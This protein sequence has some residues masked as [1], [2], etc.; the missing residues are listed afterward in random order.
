MDS[1]IRSL[2][3]HLDGGVHAAP[4]LEHACALAAAL[5]ARI[6]ALFAVSP[7]FAALPGFGAPGV[8]LLNEVDP[9]SRRH[10]RACFDRVCRDAGR[11][12]RWGEVV[13]E[14]AAA[15]FARHGLH[16]DLMVLGQHD[17]QDAAARNVPADFIESV[18]LASGTPALVLPRSDSTFRGYGCIV[19]AWKP[20]PEAAHALKAAL[21]LLQRAQEVH[22]VSRCDDEDERARDCDA[23]AEYLRLHAVEA[24]QRHGGS[25]S[26]DD[27]EAL[28]ATASRLGADLLVM[29]CYGHGRARE[30][31]LGGASRTVLRDAALP[32]LM[33]H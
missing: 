24:V 27:G 1:S 16:A 20:T 13:R 31:V 10:A 25:A 11:P 30:R 2:L 33:A 26:G 17:P 23:A 32:V 28:L 5:E 18:L 7:Q 21:A 29:G 6:D 3:V 12:L 15:G 9:E 19:V 22:L 4:R 14:E 8:P